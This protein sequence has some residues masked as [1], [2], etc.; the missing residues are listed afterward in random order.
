VV[1]VVGR[2]DVLVVGVVEPGLDNGGA[3]V[4]VEGA[5]QLRSMPRK[6]LRI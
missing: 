6:M 5:S 3:V 1:V 4:V 2:R